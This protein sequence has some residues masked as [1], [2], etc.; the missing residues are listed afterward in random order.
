MNPGDYIAKKLLQYVKQNVIPDI[1]KVMI[2][3]NSFL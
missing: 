3:K 1:R 2:A